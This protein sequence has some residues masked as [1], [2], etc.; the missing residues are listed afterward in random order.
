MVFGIPANYRFVL[1]SRSPRRRQLLEDA[2]LIFTVRVKEYDESVPADLKGR[3][4][5]EFLSR[6]KAESFINEVKDPD[7]VI[8]TADTVVWSDG[9]VL[10][11]PRDKGDAVRILR[12]ISGNTHQV[13]T[14]ITLLLR[15]S[16]NTFS[17]TTRVTFAELSDEEI[18]FYI[19]NYCPYD[20]AGAYGI[21]EWIGIIGNSYIEG[22]Y[23]N[24][25]GLPVQKLI[26]A[27]RELLKD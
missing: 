21:Q 9:K 13:I 27:L 11:K 26:S 24:V 17:E 14:G 16:L 23:F 15:G 18:D 7:E 3:E 20:K 5:A 10:D 6:V 1:A 4:I 19:S 8:I 2:G 12:N 22:S 25:M